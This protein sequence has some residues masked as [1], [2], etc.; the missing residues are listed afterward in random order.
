MEYNLQKLL[1]CSALHPKTNTIL[2]ISYNM[3][4]KRK[5]RKDGWMKERAREEGRKEERSGKLKHVMTG[6][7]PRAVAKEWTV[8]WLLCAPRRASLCAPCLAAFFLSSYFLQDQVLSFA[9]TSPPWQNQAR[10]RA[11]QF[12]PPWINYFEST[13]QTLSF[14]PGNGQCTCLHVSNFA[15]RKLGVKFHSYNIS[16]HGL[17]DGWS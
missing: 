15:S 8:G 7:E 10:S 1:K 3:R 4:K 16:L 12:N 9:F 13:H 5:G 2:S 6:R 11:L 14:S 17:Q